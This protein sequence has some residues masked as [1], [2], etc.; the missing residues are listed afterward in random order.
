MCT[1]QLKTIIANEQVIVEPRKKFFVS[2]IH[3]GVTAT[4]WAVD[5]YRMTIVYFRNRC[6]CDWGPSTRTIATFNHN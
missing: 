4:T 6:L 3:G 5:D 1:Q 2:Q